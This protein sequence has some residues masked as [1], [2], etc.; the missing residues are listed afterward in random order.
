MDSQKS[1]PPG[2][3]HNGD[4]RKR[5]SRLIKCQGNDREQLLA[6]KANVVE[7]VVTKVNTEPHFGLIKET[8]IRKSSVIGTIL[9]KDEIPICYLPRWLEQM[10]GTL[11]K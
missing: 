2:Y 6:T 11:L 5:S 7:N 1:I 10:G 4:K 9:I 8:G 3:E